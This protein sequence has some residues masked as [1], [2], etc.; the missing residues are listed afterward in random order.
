MSQE[1][2]VPIYLYRVQRTLEA[3]KFEAELKDRDD[4]RKHRLELAELQ[5]GSM[6]K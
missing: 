5:V 4:V 2:A 6:P 3:L 1:L